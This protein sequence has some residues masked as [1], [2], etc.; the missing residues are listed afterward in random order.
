MN[1]LSFLYRDIITLLVCTHYSSRLSDNL[2]I[3]AHNISLLV[4]SSD[5]II[6]HR[7]SWH[8]ETI[9]RLRVPNTPLPA[10]AATLC[11]SS[12]LLAT[13]TLILLVGVMVMVV[14]IDRVYN[15]LVG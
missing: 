3:V 1:I 5:I 7:G 11:R 9:T 2:S 14:V 4:N 15:A 12:L 13:T 10:V 6:D 8:V